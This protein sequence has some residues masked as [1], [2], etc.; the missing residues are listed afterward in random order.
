MARDRSLDIAVTGLFAR[1]PGAPGVDAWWPALLDGRVLTRRY[2]RDELLGAG[3]PQRLVDDPDYVPV[4]G[5]LPGADRFDHVLFRL[6]PREAELMDPQH[7]LMLEAA[8]AALEDAGAGPP[9]GGM[10]TGVYASSSSSGYLHRMLARGALDPL[11]LEDALHGNE[12]DF[13]AGLLS[14]RLG[15][16]GPSAAVQTACSS[17]LVAVHLAV[18]ALLHGDCDQALV[19]AAGIAFPQAG[20][21]HVPGGI[22]S[23]S[24]RCLPF[25]E[26]AD[27]VVA[28]SGVAAVVL[29]RLSE[30][31]AEGLE[32]HGVI[33]GTAV[34]NDGAARAGYYAPSAQ[35]Q[36]AVIRAAL[37]AAEVDG[38][39]VGYLEAHATGTRL[40]DPIE[41]SAASGALGAA[42]S[43]PGQ[44]A[45][46]A[47]KANIGHLDNA[48]GLASLIKAMRVVKEGTVPPVA[49]FRRLNPLLETDGS[50]LFVPDLA[51]PWSGPLP[52]R[53]GV[54]SFGIGGTNAHVVVEEPPRP[55]PSRAPAAG[56]ARLIVLSTAEPGALERSAGRLRAHLASARPEVSDVAFTLAAGRAALPERLAV[57]GR[58]A[59]AVAA[60]LAEG[61]GAVTGR[62]PA[63]GPAPLVFLFPGQGA[64]RPGMA[65]PFAEVLPGFPAALG[66]CLDAFGS[67][68]GPL[69]RALLDPHFPAAELAATELAQPALFAVEYAAAT[70]LTAL[71]IAPAAAVGHSLGEITA[72]CVCGV[73][74]LA[75][76]ARLVLTRGAAMAKCP[77][78]AMLG[79]GCDAATAARLVAESGICLEVAS[80]NGPHSS[81]LSGTEAAVEAFGAWLGDRV[82]ATRL[83]VDRAYHSALIEPALPGLAEELSGLLP[84]PAAVPFASTG[85]G[86]LVEAGERI[87]SRAF[88]R[89]TR[90]TVRFA[91]ALAAVAR[92]LPGA[93]A[94]EAGP[95]RVLS[96]AATDAGITA[97][98]LAGA[99]AGRHGEEVLTALGRLW[100]LGQPLDVAA[101]NGRGRRVHLPGYPF[102]GPAW[103]APEAAPGPPGPQG[104]AAPH[105][106]A[107]ATPAVAGPEGPGPEG[108]GPEGPG[109]EGPGPE[110][111][112]A[113]G[114]GAAPED[115]AATLAGLWR[116]LLGHEE[117][118]ETSDFFEL[119]GD[120]LLVT[121]LV[122]EV[123][124]RLGVRVPI[125]P[126]LAGRT[127][128]RQTAIVLDSM[129]PPAAPA[130]AAAHERGAQRD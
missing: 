12:P 22:H 29:R 84:R 55:A 79:L 121:H 95:G 56:P 13:T 25:D 71:G 101:L 69:R 70:A 114:G 78:G 83:R 45:V 110:G 47:L 60:R 27:G 86:R 50:P 23:P 128:G 64:Q 26:R 52:R 125:R 93:I 112:A 3:V 58:T 67:A 87:A 37:R 111:A 49:G 103:L 85:T 106:P 62:V 10:T 98:P 30:A 21:L 65:L 4:H 126:M 48:A 92:H 38:G 44:V 53:A 73:L 18:Q 5:H 39:S 122:R 104:P 59:A 32:P 76:A 115:A 123:R 102:A 40:G 120:S 54:S 119:G 61:A 129:A 105:R 90:G 118:D 113:P 17:S 15:L 16:T 28:G 19:V 33:L 66:A 88:L 42:G 51:R 107:A 36:E 99:G 74:G 24:G 34:N 94:V 41:W 11:T 91:E 130:G 80:D 109:P 89:Q 81:A 72:A 6:S 117:L 96:A 2:E 97:V 14:Y 57:A 43:R 77:P 100:C 7:R 75:E 127:L 63:G 124:Q 35:G 1:F 108:P 8:W 82:R 31:L 46:G 68:A 116:Q 9:G 20:Y